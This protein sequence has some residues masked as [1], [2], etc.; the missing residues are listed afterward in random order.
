MGSLIWCLVD[1]FVR[2]CIYNRSLEK[3]F[4]PPLTLKN[5]VRYL[6]FDFRDLNSYHSIRC[7]FS[8]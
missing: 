1:L 6:M 2:V 7:T 5:R 4:D 8:R 3:A